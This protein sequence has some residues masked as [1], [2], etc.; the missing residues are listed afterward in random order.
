MRVVNVW[1]TSLVQLVARVT[2]SEDIVTVMLI[3]SA[4]SIMSMVLK[5]LL[6]VLVVRYLG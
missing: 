2:T 3:V 5:G 4:V 1:A 6:V